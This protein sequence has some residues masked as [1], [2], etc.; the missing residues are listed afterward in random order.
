MRGRLAWPIFAA[1]ITLYLGAIFLGLQNDPSDIS[2]PLLNLVIA[3]PFPLVAA[4]LAWRRPENPIGWIM[5]GFI[6]I[7]GVE[8]LAREYAVYTKLTAPDSLPAGDFAAFIASTRCGLIGVFTFLFLLFPDGRI[9]SPRWRVV[10]YAT[11][12]LVA[13]AVVAGALD[14]PAL[15]RH[16]PE[17]EPL[18]ALRRLDNALLLVS[19][20]VGAVSVLLRFR[21][22]TGQ[23]RL[24]LKWF[25]YATCVVVALVAVTTSLGYNSLLRIREPI[26]QLEL[27][28]YGLWGLTFAALP[29]AM[30]VAILRYRLYDIDLI[31]NRTIVYG[32]VTA[33]L[34]AL[35]AGLSALTQ[36]LLVTVTGQNSDAAPITRPSRSRRRSRRCARAFRRR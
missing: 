24:Q 14:P 13:F 12:A 26:P 19:I 36:R 5:L 4:V 33:A 6:A 27:V 10:A 2:G 29:V 7:S 9:P 34:A 1:T 20:A 15:L 22:A 17:S 11:V 23:T 16:Q 30:A 3:L 25:A 28:A 31:I 32:I 21:R 18:A 35:F 8:A